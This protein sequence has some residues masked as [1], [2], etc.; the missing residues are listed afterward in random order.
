M[1]FYGFLM[2]FVYLN[3]TLK[4]LT[5]HPLTLATLRLPFKI[6]VNR[7]SVAEAGVVRDDRLTVQLRLGKRYS[8]VPTLLDTGAQINAM[9]P[10]VARS[11]GLR[12]H[13]VD[14]IHA[15][16]YDGGD[17]QALDKVVTTRTK[18]AHRGVT[19]K[20]DF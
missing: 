15:L 11:L 2:F 7:V 9:R 10:E 3:F 4:H 6:K 5:F 13:K 16:P 17:G 12:Y 14:P 8:P 18:L 19:E 1:N 20:N